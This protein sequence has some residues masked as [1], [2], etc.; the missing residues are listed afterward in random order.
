M[1]PRDLKKLKLEE[2]LAY[3]YQKRYRRRWFEQSEAA[4]EY[5]SHW[6]DKFHRYGYL[7]LPNGFLC[8]DFHIDRKDLGEYHRALCIEKASL[9]TGKVE[10]TGLEVDDTW[11][12][13]FMRN[14]EYF[15]KMSPSTHTTS[16]EFSHENSPQVTDIWRHINPILKVACIHQLIRNGK[17]K[18][19]K[20][21]LRCNYCGYNCTP[22][23]KAHNTNK[24]PTT[25]VISK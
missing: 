21:R 22:N 18:T 17:T 5:F 15:M 10:Y 9:V 6:I 3:G 24:L 12:K 14:K 8:W 25:E 7:K 11:W 23:G 20:L 4:Y 19:G 2:T 16:S 13:M 1:K